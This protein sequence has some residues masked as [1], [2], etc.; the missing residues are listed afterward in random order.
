MLTSNLESGLNSSKESRLNSLLSHEI[1][2]MNYK[3]YFENNK[4][5][6]CEHVKD[7][8]DMAD[9]AIVGNSRIIKSLVVSALN[10][11]D[12]LLVAERLAE[13]FSKVQF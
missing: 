1:L 8:N 11:K 10:D 2:N 6:R 13:K 5:S 7:I 3:V 12:A 4:A 9:F